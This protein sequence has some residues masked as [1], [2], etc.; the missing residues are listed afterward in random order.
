M[1]VSVLQHWDGLRGHL[2][3]GWGQ[4]RHQHALAPAVPSITVLS[5]DLSCTHYTYT[6]A[7]HAAVGKAPAD[8]LIKAC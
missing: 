3:R 7:A 1:H 6:F 8:V 2:F 5:A 4:P